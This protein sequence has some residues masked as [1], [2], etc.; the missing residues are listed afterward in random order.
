VIEDNATVGGLLVGVVR[1]EGYRVLRAWDVRDAIK[2][3]RDRRPDLI[4]LDLSLPYAEGLPILTDLAAAEETGRVPTVAIASPAAVV[5]T[6][7]RERLQAFVVR[8]YDVDR[9]LN[10][11]RRHLGDPEQEVP[12]RAY[13]SSDTHLNSW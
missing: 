1:E 8:P 6:D 3:A 4:V 5:P 9:L 7:Q 12:E 2:M 13:A 11:F 10:V